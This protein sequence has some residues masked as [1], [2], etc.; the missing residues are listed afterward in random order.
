MVTVAKREL[1]ARM[2][3]YFRM[4]E[5]DG[6]EL[7][8]TDRGR[9]VLKVVPLKKGLTVD[10]VFGDLRASVK[11]AKAGVLTAPTSGEWAEA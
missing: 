7:I 3:S 5:Q 9:S 6:E 11:C 1:K 10:Q 4:V 8:V 2:P